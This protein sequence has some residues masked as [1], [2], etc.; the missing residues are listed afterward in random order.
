MDRNSD[1]SVLIVD[2]EVIVRERVA[3]HV[4][5]A[6]YSIV[7]LSQDVKEALAVLDS[8]PVDIV[9][10]DIAMPSISGVEF[11]EQVRKEGNDARFIFITGYNDFSY[12]VTALKNKASDYL[13]KPIDPKGLLSAL[14]CAGREIRAERKQYE[15]AQAYDKLKDGA[16]LYRYLSGEDVGSACSPPLRERIEHPE[17]LR[18]GLLAMNEMPCESLSETA[19]FLPN[20]MHLFFLK[21]GA[22]AD[23]KRYVSDTDYLALGA[24]MTEAAGLRNEFS[25]LRRLLLK[26][27]FSPRIH[28][29]YQSDSLY[30]N[31]VHVDFAKQNRELLQKKH[32]GRLR[33]LVA[34]EIRTIDTPAALEVYTASLMNLLREFGRNGQ[35]FP[36]ED[37]SPLW[38]L[39]RF[40]SLSEY[41]GYIQGALTDMSKR[42]SD[43]SLSVVERVKAFLEANYAQP[44]L[45]LETIGLHV[46]AHPNYVSTKF[47][48]EMGMTVIEYLTSLRLEKAKELLQSTS[49][50][51]GQVAN[52]VGFQDQGYFSRCFKKKFGESPNSFSYVKI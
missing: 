4:R 6:G 13:L 18:L 36:W 43:A 2:D 15:I 5:K 52:A 29:Y 7:G 39:E 46:F 40:N 14:E 9:I 22:L 16:F 25:I 42:D 50:A 51:C 8:S 27:F 19:Y 12:A 11:L 3:L 20:G 1:I 35:D 32:Y 44:S 21:P 49:L 45:N 31:P 10:T 48:E 30:S 37:Y 47:R 33:E 23:A 28:I 34:E 41:E 17:G 26:R 24:P 38:M